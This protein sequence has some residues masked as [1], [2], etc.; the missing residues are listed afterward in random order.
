MDEQ[1]RR[2]IIKTLTWMVADMRWRFDETKLN[3]DEGSA[4]GYSPELAEAIDVLA[5]LEKD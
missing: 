3:I 2:R 5:E 4:G 1:L